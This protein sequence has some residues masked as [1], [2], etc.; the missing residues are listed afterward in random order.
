MSKI[1]ITFRNK[2][3]SKKI[4]DNIPVNFIVGIL[5]LFLFIVLTFVLTYNLDSEIRFFNDYY[6]R[7]IYYLR[8]SWYSEG[9]IPYRD[10]I[11]EY[12]QITLFIL[13]IPFFLSPTKILSDG[14]YLIS[15]TLIMFIAFYGTFLLLYRML[16]RKR[17][18]LAFLLFLPASFYF[19]YNRFDIIPTFFILLALWLINNKKY[20]YAIFTLTIAVFIKWYA[21]L[22]IPIFLNYIFWNQNKKMPWNIIFIFIITSSVIIFFTFIIGGV[23][24]I[25]APYLFHLNRGMEKNIFLWLIIPLTKIKA[26]PNLENKLLLG[27][28]IMQF[29]AI[30]I[31]LSSRIDTFRK[32][33]QWSTISILFFFIFAKFYSPQWVLWITPLLILLAN[34]WKDIFWIIALDLSSYI[35]FPIVYDLDLVFLPDYLFH[36]PLLLIYFR[37]LLIFT[38]RFNSEEKGHS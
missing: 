30:P 33:L 32:T 7:G 11:C 2:E 26:I 28:L 37:Y 1:R 8:A 38:F 4:L 29:S 25:T 31:A 20:Y 17:K 34:D 3:N 6:D 13:T 36:I 16:E 12:P 5:L 21:I 35:L 22:I 24:A 15:I 23:E 27:S 19:S 14:Q 9:K 10:T 18:K